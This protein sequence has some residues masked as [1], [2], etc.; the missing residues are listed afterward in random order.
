MMFPSFP[1]GLG[2]WG[3]YFVVV[4]GEGT[5]GSS[6]FAFALVERDGERFLPFGDLASSCSEG[7]GG[8]SWRFVP[9]S[10]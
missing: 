2:R 9:G 3:R 5:I 4:V 10:C 7:F 8:A 6:S 1:G